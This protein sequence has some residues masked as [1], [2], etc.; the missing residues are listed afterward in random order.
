MTVNKV[1]LYEYFGLPREGVK[2]GFLTAYCH[3]Q[4][5]GLVKKIRP[6]ML[7]I[8]GGGYA[9]VS[10]SENEPV[11]L[12]Y[13]AEG[14]DAFALDYSIA[15]DHYPA[16]IL[17]A[18]MAMLYLRREAAAMD[19]DPE[20]IAAV[21]FS[22]GGHLC[23]C[24]SVLWD[25]PAL[26]KAFGREACEGIRPDASVLSYPVI[27][28]DNRYWHEGS[29]VNFCGGVVAAEDY[30]L[31]KRVRANAS[32]CFLWSTSEDGCVPAENALMMYVS[33]RKAGVSAE[34]HIF[35]KGCHGMSLCNGETACSEPSAHV[36]EHNAVWFRLSL[37]FLEEHGFA[38]KKA[39]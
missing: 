4:Q 20:H 27:T 36:C 14:F 24:I 23:G 8:P 12:R 31:E 19:I 38:V 25:D 26:V 22:A 35:E 32:P 10:D 15:P 11:A 29:F 33:L 5:P 9:F 7:V 17:E 30:S 6:A 37:E 1:D 18:G 28:A 3:G 2:G 13:F 21:G 16:Q 39:G 34:L